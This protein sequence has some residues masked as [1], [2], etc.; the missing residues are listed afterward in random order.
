MT[1]VV[2]N[3]CY[4]GF[5]LSKKAAEK[6]AELGV[7]EA[8]EYLKEKES[9]PLYLIKTPRH[10]PRLVQVVEELGKESWGD[11]AKLKIEEID[12]EIYRI[13]DYDGNERVEL[14]DFNMC[15]WVIIK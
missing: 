12:C 14:P 2:Y 9:Y 7:E 6:L 10:D 13:S 4:G 1:K 5:G 15:D 8:I 11:C 3:A